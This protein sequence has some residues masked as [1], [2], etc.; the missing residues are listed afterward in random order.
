MN[1]SPTAPMYPTRLKLVI[2]T[3]HE[4]KQLDDVETEYQNLSNNEDLSE[5]ELLDKAI[6]LEKQRIELFK[7]SITEVTMFKNQQ[8]S[9]LAFRHDE[10]INPILDTFVRSV[11]N[12]ISDF[13]GNLECIINI[14]GH[15][16][17][18][19]MEA[20]D[21]IKYDS[22]YLRSSGSIF[23]MPCLMAKYIRL[24]ALE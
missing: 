1:Q 4:N 15:K 6:E 13:S 11:E 5:Q 20:T 16:Y 9:D 12:K 3:D 23:K 19:Y 2:D 24:V 14:Q 10:T 17:S 7:D 8:W 22:E 18:C 21:Y